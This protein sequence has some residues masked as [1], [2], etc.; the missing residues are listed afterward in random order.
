MVVPQICFSIFRYQQFI[1]HSF[2]GTPILG[3]LNI[4]AIVFFSDIPGF[5][6]SRCLP[7]YLTYPTCYV[8]SYGQ[9][10]PNCPVLT[11]AQLNTL[12]AVIMVAVI[13]Q[14]GFCQTLDSNKLHHFFPGSNY[15]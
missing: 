1:N 13:I 5:H 12:P 9:A 6:Q 3:H 7:V 8:G 14:R 10:Y 4:S 11:Y 15:I 2:W